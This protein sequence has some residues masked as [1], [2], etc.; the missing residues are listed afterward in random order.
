MKP[1]IITNYDVEK[2]EIKSEFD[3]KVEV[4]RIDIK[5]KDKKNG[6][7]KNK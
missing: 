7:T 1:V 2:I 5:L 4:L 6:T 3:F